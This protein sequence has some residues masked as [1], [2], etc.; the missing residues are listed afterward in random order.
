MDLQAYFETNN[1]IGVLSTADAKGTVN[2]AVYSRPHIMD[3]GTVAFIMANRLSH[4]NLESNPHASYLF[5]EQGRGYQGK[6]FS[7]TKVREEA[8]TPLLESLR[9]RRYSPG[10]EKSMKPLYLVF[11]KIDQELPLVGAN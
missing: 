7:L 8:D 2:S 3:D 9:R 4:K 11:F 5:V 6:R 10:E 1:G